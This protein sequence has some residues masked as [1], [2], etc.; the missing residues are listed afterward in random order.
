MNNKNIVFALPALACNVR[1]VQI[2]G[3][4]VSAS[5]GKEYHGKLCNSK[6]NNNSNNSN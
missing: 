3:A 6:I 2:E 1:H 4:V 5:M